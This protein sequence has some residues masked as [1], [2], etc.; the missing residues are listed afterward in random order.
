M[1]RWTAGF[2]HIA[3]F[4]AGANSIGPVNESSSVLS[5]SSAKPQAALAKQVGRRGGDAQQLGLVGQFDVR[6]ERVVRVERV[7]DDRPAGEC[8]ERGRR[9]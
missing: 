3:L 4:I 6:A 2:S 8:A 5:R 7:A 1:L 9:R